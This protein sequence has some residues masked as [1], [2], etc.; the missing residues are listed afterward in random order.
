MTVKANLR[1]NAYK[2]VRFSSKL[3]FK[4]QS[5]VEMIICL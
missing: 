4:D 5:R 2:L 1:T 3:D